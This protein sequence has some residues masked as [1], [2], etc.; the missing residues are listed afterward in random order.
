VPTTGA[1]TASKFALRGLTKVVALEEGKHGVRCN[2]VCPGGGNAEMVS[3]FFARRPELLRGDVEVDASSRAVEPK[4][5]ARRAELSELAGAVLYFAS[6]DSTF[7]TGTELVV[8]GG[9]HAGMYV[10]V[11]GMF[12]AR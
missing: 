5:I 1:Y 9:L 8:D 4:P 2:I 11:P 10:D 6:D 12:S 7:C 3:E